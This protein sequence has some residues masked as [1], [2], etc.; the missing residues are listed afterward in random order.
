MKSS[1]NKALIYIE[2]YLIL[3]YLLTNLELVQFASSLNF[4]SPMQIGV[5]ELI[6]D[7]TA[8]DL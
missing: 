5:H 8:T 6:W 3:Q 4:T 1:T 2:P 7:E